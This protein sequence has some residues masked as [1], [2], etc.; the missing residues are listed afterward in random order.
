[1]VAAPGGSPSSSSPQPSL[2]A[3]PQSL[4]FTWTISWQP[5]YQLGLLV[6]LFVCLKSPVSW[7]KAALGDSLIWCGWKFN[8][9]S[10]KVSLEPDKL[11]KL[12]EQDPSPSL[13]KKGHQESTSVVP[14][15][16]QLGHVHQPS[17][18]VIYGTTVLGSAQPTLRMWQRFLFSLGPTCL[19]RSRRVALVCVFAN[20]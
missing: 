3:A 15:P 9:R 16:S 13:S 7:K 4:A 5:S 10:E 11:A 18:Q 20:S 1:M 17:P 6:V 12:A 19:S 14:W 2:T 8:F